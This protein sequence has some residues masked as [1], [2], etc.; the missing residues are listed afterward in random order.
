MHQPSRYFPPVEKADRYGVLAVGGALTPD[1]LLDAYTHGIFPWPDAH[2]RIEWCSP[3]VRAIFEFHEFHISRQLDRT[4]RRGMFQ[5]TCDRTFR[6]VMTGCA[7]QADRV[8]ATWITPALIDAY[9]ELHKLGY[10][11]S[12]ETWQDGELVGGVYGVAIGAMF[13]AESMFHHVS[14]ASKVA[15]AYLIRHLEAS[16]YEL[17]D[18]QQWTPNSASLGCR[19][20]LRADFIARLQHALLSRPDF[21][22][23]L[24]GGV[25]RRTSRD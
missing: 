10:A 21:G 14:D 4:L 12:V 22:K 7:T 18:I 16:R 23:E 19:P 8:G 6:Q 17:V 5:V 24:R 11:H 13:A 1:R 20:I 9:C 15:L 2:G 3:P 25:P